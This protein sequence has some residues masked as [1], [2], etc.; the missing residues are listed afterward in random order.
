MASQ[1]TIKPPLAGI[2]RSRGFQSQP[3]FS[4]RE[5]ENFWPQYALTGA[6][7]VA[8]RP[9]LDQWIS[10]ATHPV[11][12]LCRVNGTNSST[13]QRTFVAGIN[14]TLHRWT[15]SALQ[16]VGGSGTIPTGRAAFAAAFEQKVYIPASTSLV[17]D[18]P[19]NVLSTWAASSGTLPADMRI[20][21]FWA[22][23]LWGSARPDTPHIVYGCASGNP[24]NWDFNGET[25]TSAFA[26]I[27]DNA[28]LISD[29]VTALIPVSGD[30]M[31]VSTPDAIYAWRGHPRRG[32]VADVLNTSVGVRGQGAWT[33]GPDG[34][35]FAIT[36]KGLVAIQGGQAV[37]LISADR[38]PNSLIGYNYDYLDP[39]VM[40]AFDARFNCVHITVRGADAASSEAWIYDLKHGGLW[41][42]KFAQYP[43]VMCRFDPIGTG[44]ASEVLLGGAGGLYRF[45]LDGEENIASARLV[46]GPVRLTNIA[47]QRAGIKEAQVCFSGAT[48]AGGATVGF[49]VG[50][51]ADSSYAASISGESSTKY[52]TTVAQVFK[53][54][55]VVRPRIA[56]HAL[57]MVI[58]HDA[59][60]N[61]AQIEFEETSLILEPA[62]RSRGAVFHSDQSGPLAGSF[63]GPPPPPPRPF[64]GAPDNP[65]VLQTAVAGGALYAYYPLDET[66]ETTDR[67]DTS[68]AGRHLSR[69]QNGND[70]GVASGVLGNGFCRGSV[71]DNTPITDFDP[72]E[73][74]AIACWFQF[75]VDPA[76][77]LGGR[78]CMTLGD[79]NVQLF[80]SATH[81]A[82]GIPPGLSVAPP[83]A[84]AINDSPPPL[85]I[86]RS[87][88]VA[89]AMFPSGQWRFLV[90]NYNESTGGQLWVD[91]FAVPLALVVPKGAPWTQGLGVDGGQQG[92]SVP[93]FE[94][95]VDE[96]SVWRR[97]LT[98]SEMAALYHQGVGRAYPFAS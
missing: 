57:T 27:G 44:R 10:V 58:D 31:L 64:G 79:L 3:P 37:Q 77:D 28:G 19:T 82:F 38:L 56:D 12:L 41:E 65:A 91:G 83:A 62:G 73:G 29:P 16:A 35:I 55:G 45:D 50:P 32:G 13:P 53:N 7:T 75:G 1:L 84:F 34:S 30:T 5:A 48:N 9:P 95:S 39:R 81:A 87:P 14:G 89:G 6:E 24:L 68:G 69:G 88:D 8:V 52:V 42:Q 78:T 86:A 20:L 26:T 4:C 36:N 2:V 93:N 54:R 76:A 22:G 46:V 49:Y 25:A 23:G 18:Y 40:M 51:T 71:F 15:G 80:A 97:A 17:Y 60:L 90:L 98:T 94:N 47:T 61:N 85:I 70:G 92:V 96:V 63:V 11:N 33:Q 72:G 59:A 67:A 66:G 43:H 74:F 21:V